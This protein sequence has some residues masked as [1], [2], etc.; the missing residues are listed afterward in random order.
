MTYVACVVL[1]V[2]AMI[3]KAPQARQASRRR[4]P[5]YPHLYRRPAPGEF[6]SA[7]GAGGLQYQVCSNMLPGGS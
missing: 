6:V 7:G 5:R 3:H 2:A 4:R 1:I